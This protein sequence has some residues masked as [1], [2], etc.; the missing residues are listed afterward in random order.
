MMGWLLHKVRTMLWT[1]F[2][3]AFANLFFEHIGKGCRFHG[4]LDIRQRGGH[5]WLGDRV[6]V[7]RRTIWTVLDGARLS[8]GDGAYIG[9]GV[10]ISAHQSVSI[11]RDTLVAE[12][13]SI[14]DNEHVWSDIH[15]PIGAQG[16]TTT[17]CSIGNGC[18]IGAGAKVLRG[19][20][21]G[22]NCILGAGAVLKKSLPDAV[23]A[24]GV[25]ARVVKWRDAIS[26]M[27]DKT[28]QVG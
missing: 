24:V 27:V 18:W 13:V 19:G 1:G 21:L 11:G 25:P 14:Y 10:M 28:L 2:Y 23:V 20:S 17:V 9:N 8:L 26:E 7:S 15:M 22:D 16:Y 3:Y 6:C 4:A 12:Y 5:I